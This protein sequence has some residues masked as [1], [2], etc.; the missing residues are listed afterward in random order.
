VLYE[1]EGINFDRLYGEADTTYH[2]G[3]IALSIALIT[4]KT[5]LIALSITQIAQ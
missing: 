3:R 4:P 5:L 1:G 2:L